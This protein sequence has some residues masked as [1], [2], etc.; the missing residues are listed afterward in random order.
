MKSFFI[1]SRAHFSHV[2]SH[3]A[4]RSRAAVAVVLVFWVICVYVWSF[5]IL[6][7]APKM[8]CLCLFCMWQ[9]V[10]WKRGSERDRLKNRVLV[11]GGLFVLWVPAWA[12]ARV[13]A[14]RDDAGHGSVQTDGVGPCQSPCLLVELIAEARA[15]LSALCSTFPTREAHVM[16]W[17]FRTV[18]LS[19]FF[20]VVVSGGGGGVKQCVLVLF[21]LQRWAVSGS[22]AL[23]PV[24]SSTA[25]VLIVLSFN[26]TLFIVLYCAVYSYSAVAGK[27]YPTRDQLYLCCRVLDECKQAAER[28]R[29]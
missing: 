22:L 28:S 3:E 15:S 4:F 29:E 7:G 26:S 14:W 13:P 8:T 5:A 1:V 20:L 25:I 12:V 9:C 17:I 19:L 18:F 21:T 23:M 11:W 24:G 6:L 2:Q 27:K 10:C 16:L